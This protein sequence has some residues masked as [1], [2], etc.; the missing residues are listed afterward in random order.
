MGGSPE[1]SASGRD[2]RLARDARERAAAIRDQV[3]ELTGIAELLDES[4]TQILGEHVDPD[5][6]QFRRERARLLVEIGV[7]DET[8][9]RLR[10]LY[11]V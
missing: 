6:W 4:T 8:R 3:R 2:L 10:R 9:D 7:D 1:T 11:G 5:L